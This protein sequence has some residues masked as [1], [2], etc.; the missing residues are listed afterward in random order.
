MRQFVMGARIN[1]NTNNYTGGMADAIRATNEFA[2]RLSATDNT[3]GRYYDS[4]GRLRESN[5]RYA[6]A[7][8]DATLAGNVFS[9]TLKVVKVGAVAL[10]TALGALGAAAG[11]MAMQV[12]EANGRIKA[13]TGVTTEQAK[14][15][16]ATARDVYAQGWGPSLDQAAT[17][18][19][20]FK[21]VI[22]DVNSETAKGFYIIEQVSNME[23]PV[24]ETAKVIKTMTETFDGLSK[25]DAMDIITTGFQ[26]GGNYAG[27]LLDTMNEYSMQF[28]GL[29]M[30]AEVMMATLL[31]GSREGAFMLDKVG[32]SV[33]E[34]FIRLQDGS[35]SSREAFA[36]LGLDANKMENEIAAGGDAANAAFQ[37]MLLGLGNV[38]NAREREQLGVA[39]MGTQWEDM[40]DSVILA[41]TE[42]QKGL[43]DFRG[44]TA[45]A[46]EDLQNNL[47]SKVDILR[48]QFMNGL[49]DIGSPIVDGLKK[50]ADWAIANM[51][52]ILNAI[53]QVAQVVAVVLTPAFVAFKAVFGWLVD[54]FP[55]VS[56]YIFGVAVALFTLGAYFK[57]MQMRIQIVFIAM[58]ALFFLLSMNPI[59]LIAIAVGLLI[60]YLIRLAGGW[61]AVKQKIVEFLPTLQAIGTTILN[62]V[63]PILQSFGSMFMA[64]WSS[65]KIYVL[66][67]VNEII[68]GIVA[69]FQALV[70]FIQEHWTLISAIIA[71]AWTII[72]VYIQT[73]IAIAKAV[74]TT[75]FAVIAA[76][77]SMVWQ[78]IKGVISTVWIWITGMI[79]VGLKL[80]KGDWK[81]AWEEM[82]KTLDGV[83]KNVMKFFT[84]LKDTFFKSGKAIITTLADGIKSVAN[85]P[86]K[87]IEDVLGKVRDFLPFSDAKVGPLSQLTHN[88]G[89]I[90]TTM[91]EGIYKQRSALAAAMDS[92]LMNT[93]QIGVQAAVDA[94]STNVAAGTAD[95]AGSAAGAT[96]VTK[97]VVIEKLVEKIEING[98]GSD[99]PKDLA[100]QILGEMYELLKGA[101][102]I[103]AAGL[104][105]LL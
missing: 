42:G 27:D 39:L 26:R 88:G 77:I 69:G 65:I 30:S 73:G 31:A 49:A 100:R 78:V 52:T 32:D 104:G 12:D 22:G 9:Q 14:Q 10:A 5:G 96:N 29:G 21:Q 63:M 86:M 35:D 17:D 47:T 41:M 56:P 6:K 25:T 19:A 53:S 4:Q 99:N 3:M 81:G 91:A 45:Q 101:D 76:N 67:A 57:I 13:M 85:A 15:L 2:N 48:R 70:G 79:K 58:R 37:A 8:R 28:E 68:F 89:K 66:P 95:P 11:A 71:V 80:L 33:K 94:G 43:G 50:A 20:T 55:I 97:S 84:N 38:K 44:A 75:G 54:I 92:V 98:T 46:G 36:A 1:L 59:T 34:A 64:I 103:E 61:G 62:A 102:E 16:T 83:G 7:T 87:A 40:G 74:I 51:P 93:P 105:D 90:V 24:N 60:G 18:M 23:A 72:S 82:L